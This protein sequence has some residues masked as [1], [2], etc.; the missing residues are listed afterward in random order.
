MVLSVPTSTAGGDDV[1]RSLLVILIFIDI[2][3]NYIESF[4]GPCNNNII[5]VLK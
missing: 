5:L 4:V 2:R 3:T 1:C